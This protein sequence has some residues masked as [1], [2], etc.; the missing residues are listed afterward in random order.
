[1]WLTKL[2]LIFGGIFAGLEGLRR[3]QYA[4]GY[5]RPV[6][7]LRR[8]HLDFSVPAATVIRV[9]LKQGAPESRSGSTHTTSSNRRKST[10][11]IHSR[12]SKGAPHSKW[13]S[14][15]VQ[16]LQ[17]TRHAP[18]CAQP[19]NH[20]AEARPILLAPWDATADAKG[21][22]GVY[23]RPMFRVRGSQRATESS[24]LFSFETDFAG[25]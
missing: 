16:A 2:T 24:I 17:A 10:D 5:R 11:L 8:H 7:A 20:P 6:L 12:Y 3:L 4:R 15:G 22:I 21:S 18:V 23:N 14:P 19:F 1:M 13:R 9:P 25:G